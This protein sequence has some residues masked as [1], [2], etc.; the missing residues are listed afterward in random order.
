MRS[1][2]VCTLNTNGDLQSAFL[3][4]PSLP[5]AYADFRHVAQIPTPFRAT[6]FA[7]EWWQIS[8]FPPSSAILR[9]VHL[10]MTTPQAHTI[11]SVIETLESQRKHRGIKC[12]RQT[13][14]NCLVELR[15]P[16][17]WESQWNE[18]QHTCQGGRSLGR[19]RRPCDLR[20]NS[21]TR[22]NPAAC[23][24]LRIGASKNVWRHDR[25]EYLKQQPEIMNPYRGS[26]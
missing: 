22:G 5:R 12:Q 18:S 4:A 2:I 15:R 21:E 17:F 10:K 25:C 26:C 14:L 13:I 7:A 11:G 3:V 24:P 16:N 19:N 23:A 8:W 20:P 1:I 9:P 6:S